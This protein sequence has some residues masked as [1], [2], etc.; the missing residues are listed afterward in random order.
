MA[1]AGGDG[2]EVREEED[3]RGGCDEASSDVLSA[4]CR[5]LQADMVD[6]HSLASK[7]TLTLVYNVEL[8]ELLFDVLTRYDG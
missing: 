5:F 6:V 1:E 2:G 7:E 4:L 8:L 3:G